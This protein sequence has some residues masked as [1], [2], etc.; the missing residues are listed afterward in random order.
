[1]NKTMKVKH[2]FPAKQPKRKGKA[3]TKAQRLEWGKIAALGCIAPLMIGRCNQAATI[4][5]CGTGAGGRK[6]HDFVIG[7]CH[8]HH[9]GK[10]GIDSGNFSKRGWQ[11]VYDTEENLWKLTHKLLKRNM[12]L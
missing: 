2:S 4:H 7:L 11:T 1:M 5:H 3:P 12:M 8:E 9:M 10:F 6:D